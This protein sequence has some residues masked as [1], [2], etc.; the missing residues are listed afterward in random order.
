MDCRT[1]FATDSRSLRELL[2]GGDRRSIARSNAALELLRADRSRVAELAKLVADR[3]WLVV[4]RATDLM[5]KL[6]H[7]RPA[8]VQ[9]YR[10]LFI[11]RLA[12]HD[13][14]EIRLQIAR[15][16]PLL[17][18]TPDERRQVL[19]ILRRYVNDPQLFVKAW[20]LD[21]LSRFAASDP[22]LKPV[23]RRLLR[24]FKQSDSPALRSRAAQIET[25]LRDSGAKRRV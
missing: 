3:D 16:L 7:E 1:A 4:M 18:W 10:R 20:S 12:D 9:R 15:A 6:A 19:R 24:T 5:E 23:V 14:W 25:R 13:S 11:G 17:R 22:G 21:S 8:W 2:T